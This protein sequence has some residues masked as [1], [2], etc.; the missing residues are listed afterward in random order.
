MADDLLADVSS[1]DRALPY[2]IERVAR[3]LRVHLARVLA[4]QGHGLSPQ[5]WFM[6]FR[7]YE[8]DGRSQ[9]ELTDATLDDRPNV[10]RQVRGLETA[11]Y[12]R[13]AADPRDGRRTLVTLTEA[14]RACVADML[15]IAVETRRTLFEGVDASA[16]AAFSDVLDQLERNLRS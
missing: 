13:R 11:G 15:P 10:S 12:V 2:R 8:R 5:Q 4:E 3:L 16:L 7:L 9:S 6:L 14:G 1:L